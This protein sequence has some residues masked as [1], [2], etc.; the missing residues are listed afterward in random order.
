[1]QSSPQGNAITESYEGDVLH[2]YLDSVGNPTI[3]RGHLIVAGE[4]F[5]AGITQD[6]ADALYLQDKA[7][8]YNIVNT[9]CRALIEAG[10]VS[11]GEFD[12]LSDACFNMGD[13]LKA[14]TLLRLLVAGDNAGA[15]AQLARWDNAGGKPNAA[16]HARRVAEMA[17]WTA[18]QNG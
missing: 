7:K 14:S 8:A 18:G 5:S 4:D 16:L 9:E 1:M 15:E 2:V 11:Q 12:A 3:G 6:Q 17:L 13:F 10:Q